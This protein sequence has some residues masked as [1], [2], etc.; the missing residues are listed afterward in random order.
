[1]S[2][3]QRWAHNWVWCER[4][5]K[6][7]PRPARHVDPNRMPEWTV[8]PCPGPHH[9]II[10]ERP[11]EE[12]EMRDDQKTESP[13]CNGALRLGTDREPRC[14][15]DDP[16]TGERSREHRWGTS[17]GHW[18]KPTKGEDWFVEWFDDTPTAY[19]I[20]PPPEHTHKWGQWMGV[21]STHVVRQCLSGHCQVVQEAEVSIVSED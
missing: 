16:H 5:G 12:P 15:R 18:H 20:T 1:M 13:Q 19:R 4:G 8:P 7:Q 14:N 9:P 6:G 2:D 3:G 17:N 11:D 10:V 21:A